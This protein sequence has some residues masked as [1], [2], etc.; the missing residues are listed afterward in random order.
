M[1]KERDW[2][3]LNS[4]SRSI[5]RA[6]RLLNKWNL[7]LSQFID[8]KLHL[9]TAKS[10]SFLNDTRKL[11]NISTAQANKKNPLA[12]TIVKRVHLTSGAL[13]RKKDGE[14]WQ[15]TSG[16]KKSRLSTYNSI[17]HLPGSK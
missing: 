5:E 13:H 9:Q 2:K 4:T 12:K 8:E 1:W 17:C 6:L 15:F 7:T 3:G 16:A 14:T 11:K 10:L